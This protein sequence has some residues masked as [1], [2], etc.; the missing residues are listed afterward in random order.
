MDHEGDGLLLRQM[1]DHD[2]AGL[3]LT[4]DEL[5]AAAKE[6]ALPGTEEVLPLFRQP[7]C[8]QVANGDEI[9]MSLV[10]EA[11]LKIA[12]LLTNEQWQDRKSEQ[13]C[14][15]A[16]CPSAGQTKQFSMGGSDDDASR[17]EGPVHPIRVRQPFWLQ[18][19]Q[20]TKEQFS[21][22]DAEYLSATKEMLDQYAKHPNCPAIEVT[23]YDAF[24]FAKWIGGR[25]PTE[26][27]WEYACRAGTTGPW[28]CAV[29]KLKEYA[30]I[31][32]PKTNP[33]RQLQPNSWQLYDMH[34]NV[35][36]WC[37]DWYNVSH[38]QTRVDRDRQ[39]DEGGPRSGSS[40]V[41]RGGNFRDFPRFCRSSF[42]DV[43]GP[44]Y[45][46]Y[47]IGFRVVRD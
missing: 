6:V 46:G 14:N 9:A 36:E 28:C 41:L 10:Q 24:C 3:P 38:Y 18:A 17:N 22:F 33:T 26:T 25:L 4:G 12:G 8:Q 19:G 37:W 32:K 39:D 13:E 43:D 30:W 42:R 47:G 15:F 31:R 20:V 35:A 44:V 1:G 34:G 5:Q 27:E 11:G 23:W 2:D 40:R 16:R 45:H 21:L 7:F 29:E